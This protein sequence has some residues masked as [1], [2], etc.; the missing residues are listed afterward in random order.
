MTDGPCFHMKS[1]EDLQCL[2]LLLEMV[3]HRLCEFVDQ[4]LVLSYNHANTL[5]MRCVPN[6]LQRLKSKSLNHKYS[7]Q[8]QTS[9]LTP[10][11]IPQSRM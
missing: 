10:V 11:P 9:N 8:P 1:R 7:T 3:K 2:L 4:L 6:A 5:Y